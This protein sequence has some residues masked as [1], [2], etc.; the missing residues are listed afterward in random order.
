MM[1]TLWCTLSFSYLMMAEALWFNESR[2]HGNVSKTASSSHERWTLT[3]DTGNAK[4]LDCFSTYFSAQNN[5]KRFNQHLSNIL[6]MYV[7]VG[8]PEFM[9]SWFMIFCWDLQKGKSDELTMCLG[10][11]Q[12]SAPSTDL[13][14]RTRWLKATEAHVDACCNGGVPWSDIFIIFVPYVSETC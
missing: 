11:S 13:G 2:G 14:K 5:Q 4:Q 12:L 9:S 10:D 7:F 6:Y 3:I 8:T 1:I